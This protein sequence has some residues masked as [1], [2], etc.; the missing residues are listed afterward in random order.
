VCWWYYVLRSLEFHYGLILKRCFRGLMKG[1]VFNPWLQIITNVGQ[2]VVVPCNQ[3]VKEMGICL[4]PLTPKTLFNDKIMIKLSFKVDNTSNAVIDPND[5]ILR[6]KQL[7]FYKESS[8]RSILYIVL[9]SL[10]GLNRL[11]SWIIA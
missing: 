2:L 8:L 1:I 6:S 7:S 11:W 10:N 4:P 3:G 9:S 5:T